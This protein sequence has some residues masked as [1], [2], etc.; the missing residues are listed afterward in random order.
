MDA[1]L[2]FYSY[3]I[4]NNVYKLT[5]ADGQTEITGCGTIGIP[6]LQFLHAEVG[7]LCAV[8]IY[9]TA[10]GIL[11]HLWQSFILYCNLVFSCKC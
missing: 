6:A 3:A 1:Y 10:Q 4:Y 5:H 9:R 11:L 2:M 8:L 7:M